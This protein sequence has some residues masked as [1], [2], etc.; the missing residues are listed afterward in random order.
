MRY[1]EKKKTLETGE[2]VRADWK[3]KIANNEIKEKK[4]IKKWEI[5]NNILTKQEIWQNKSGSLIKTKDV[6]KTK[7]MYIATSKLLDKN[8]YSLECKFL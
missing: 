4:N 5:E 1:I 2:R 3:G 8:N 7:L 6:I